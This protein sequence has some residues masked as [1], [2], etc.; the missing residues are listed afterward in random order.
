[1]SPPS[2]LIVSRE[3]LFRLGLR[4]LLH[5]FEKATQCFEATSC[6]EART[7]LEHAHPGIA[8]VADYFGHEDAARMIKELHRARPFL[9]ALVIGRSSETTDVQRFLKAGALGFV[10]CQDHENELMLAITAVRGGHLHVSR[11]AAAGLLLQQGRTGSRE[12]NTESLLSDREREVF[13]LVG[14]GMGCKQIAMQLNISIKTVETH[15]MRMRDKLHLNHASEL[16]RIA[17]S[18]R[19][20]G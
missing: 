12:E 11:N 19:K 10:T 3:P 15:K 2:V 13:R 6:Q 18:T 20:A 16:T 5:Q 1:M 8:V 7:L 14:E 4:C 17:A 9:P